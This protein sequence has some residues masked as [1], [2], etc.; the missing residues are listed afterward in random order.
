MNS[1]A[2]KDDE[3]DEGWLLRLAALLT[4]YPHLGAAADLAQMTRAEAWGLYCYVSR[5]ALG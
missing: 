1:A 3:D 4:R 2:D 5:L